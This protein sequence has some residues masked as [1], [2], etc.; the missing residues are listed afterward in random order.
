MGEAT[1]DIPGEAPAAGG[2]SIV[3]DIGYG[4]YSST[5]RFDDRFNMDIVQHTVSAGVTWL[6]GNNWSFRAGLGAILAG[7]LGSGAGQHEFLPGALASFTANWRTLTSQGARPFVDLSGSLAGSWSQTEFSG[8]GSDTWLALDARVGVRAGWLL[9]QRLS[10]YLHARAFGGPAVWY[11]GGDEP[12]T[13]TDIY[14]Y[15][16]GAGL[17]L[18]LDGWGLYAEASPLGEQ[19][20]FGGASLYF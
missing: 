20:Y 4:Y 15:Q 19:S 6:A 11:G 13:G 16:V 10:P 3:L 1:G 5:L 12:A 2:T 8:E 14:H 7:N 18:F 9:W 17:S